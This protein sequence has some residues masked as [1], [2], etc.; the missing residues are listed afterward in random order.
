M[1]QI[2]MDIIHV[3]SMTSNVVQAIND[4]FAPNELFDMFVDSLKHTHIISRNHNTFIITKTRLDKNTDVSFLEWI[5]QL[6]ETGNSS[7][8]L[9]WRK[10]L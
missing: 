3:Q 1:K 4:T 9:L 8:T 10:S 5:K 2:A 6:I 7:R